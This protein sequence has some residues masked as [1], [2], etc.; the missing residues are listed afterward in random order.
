MAR[1]KVEDIIKNVR[2]PTHWV[3][4]LILIEKGDGKLRICLDLRDLNRAI[5]KT[6]LPHEK[7]LANKMV[8]H[9]STN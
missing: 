2:G 4:S 9:S 5:Q 1:M 3:N 8:N 6:L 7:T